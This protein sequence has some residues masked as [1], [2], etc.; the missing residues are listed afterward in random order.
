MQW[1][2]K[3]CIFLT[4]KRGL[5]FKHYR[6]R[7]GGFTRQQPIPCL[8]MDCVCTFQSFNALKVHLSKWHSQADIGQSSKP[9]TVFHC[10]VCEY[11]EPCTEAEFFTHVRSHLKLK[12]KVPCPYEGCDFQSSVYSTFNAHKSRMHSG[13]TT[14]FKTEVRSV[15]SQTE[16]QHSEEGAET[17]TQDDTLCEVEDSADNITDLESQLERNLASLFL[18]MQTILHVPEY[19]V[20]E[21]TQRLNQINLLSQPVL[22]TA[23]Q[24]IISQHCVNV[25][26]NYV[27][28]EIMNAVLQN[29]ILFKHTDKD[30]SLSTASKRAS[31]ITQEFPVVMPVEYP[32]DKNGNSVVYVPILKMLQALLSHKDILEKALHT[33]ALH[34]ENGYHSFRDGTSFKGNALLNV[35]EFRIVLGLYIDEFEVANPLG[36]SKK[37]HK[38]C[39]IYWVLANLDSKYRSTLH[40]IQLAVLCKDSSVQKHGYQEVLRPLIQDLVTLEEHGVYVEQLA[41]SVKGTVLYVSADNLGA[42]SLAGFQ[43]SFAAN[44]FCR[45]CLCP[46]NDKD[47]EVRSGLHQ[48]RTRESHDTHVQEVFHDRTMAKHYGVKRGCPLSDKLTYFHVVDGF[49]PDILH[50]FLEGVVP[51]ELALCLQSFIAKKYVSLDS[52]NEAIRKFPYTFS[53]KVDQPQKIPK[54]FFLKG[55][56][57]GNGHEN[58]SLLR[59]L[60]LIVGHSIPEGDEA[61][62]T[63]MLLKD[64]VEIVMSSHFNDE[65]IDFLDCKISEH[66]EL[67]QTTFPNYRLRPKHH[68]IEH[69]PQM[70]KIFGPLIDVWTMRFEGK[71]KFFKQVVHDT[72]NFK[73]VALTLAVRHQKTMGL[74]LDSSVFFKPAVQIDKVQ[75]VLVKSFPDHIQSLLQQQN[76]QQTTAMERFKIRVIVTDQDIQKLS[77]DVK[78]QTVQELKVIVQEHCH[79]QYEFNM[80]YEDPD[81][82][83]ALCNLDNMDDLPAAATVKVVPLLTSLFPE[84]T[85]NSSDVSISSADTFII[86]SSSRTQGWPEFFQIPVFSVDVEFRLRQAN[87]AYLKDNKAFK[88]PWDMKRNILQVLAEEIYKFDTYPDEDRLRAVAR[89]LIAKHPCLT[90]AGSTDG[91]SSW[92]NS[93]YFK[94]G[95][96]RTKLRKAGCAEVSINSGKGSPGTSPV[97]RGLKRPK[98]CEVNFLPELPEKENEETLEALRILLAEEM[99]KEIQMLLS[100]HQKWTRLFL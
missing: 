50:D 62:E 89:A 11:G 10:Q 23:V 18:E 6:L 14:P 31:Y 85:S 56:I 59:L 100:L 74:Y 36:T 13:C 44:H 32:L 20:Q 33:E 39:A 66:R 40:T 99:K 21:V 41:E 15:T 72:R 83:N 53:D 29:N 28:S 34:T 81:F 58:R 93:L 27:V 65:L 17:S 45:F 98:R 61:W 64:M 5:L 8:H 37:K 52:V 77:L 7:H 96:F 3:H 71:H 80:M 51:V 38:L 82:G 95:N 47:K 67:L 78:P 75:S 49:P 48:P 84:V 12:Q 35:D 1:K 76:G 43:E 91:C 97:S 54:N 60:P 46:R 25:D 73:N 26:V 4:D 22:Q 57:G 87:L 42:H 92:K 16:D 70:V 2:C 90:E 86:P 88:C 68:F 30:G 24:K 19:A 55:T 63:L 79:L 9:V 69:Y 94:M